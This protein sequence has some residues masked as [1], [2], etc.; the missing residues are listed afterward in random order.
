MKSDT[1]HLEFL[2]SQYVDGTLDAASR[3]SIEQQLLTDPVARKLYQ[4]HQETQDVLDDFGSRLPM[5]NW[6][7][8]EATLGER[9]EKEA[10]G[11]RSKIKWR[12]WIMPASIAAGLMIAVGGGFF[13]G[14][15]IRAMEAPAGGPP[16]IVNPAPVTPSRDVEFSVPQNRVAGHTSVDYTGNVPKVGAGVA[17]VDLIED[18]VAAI[19]KVRQEGAMDR[20]SIGRETP[21]A[22]WLP[23]EA[24]RAILTGTTT[25]PHSDSDS[26]I[27]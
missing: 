6:S 9:L 19:D 20:W 14:Y 7:E 17:K 25:R 16:I 24:P 12:K 26:G 5:I 21:A 1:Q 11:G 18:P 23:Q 15:V 22:I 27:Q 3:K 8:F 13:F 4:E 10:G 2:I